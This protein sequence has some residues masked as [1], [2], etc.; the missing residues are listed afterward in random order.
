VAVA[1]FLARHAES[2]IT[3]KLDEVY[4][5]EHE[6]ASVSQDVQWMQAT[7]IPEERW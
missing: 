6:T 5:C 1:E 3:E 4:V 2:N 7:S